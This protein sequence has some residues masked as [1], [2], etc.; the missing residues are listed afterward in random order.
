MTSVISVYLRRSGCSYCFIAAERLLLSLFSCR[1]TAVITV[2]LQ[3]DCCYHR[4]NAEEVVVAEFRSREGAGSIVVKTHRIP[5]NDCSMNERAQITFYK[6]I[7]LCRRYCP[8]TY[9]NSQ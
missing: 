5:E 6:Y 7:E 1:E 9:T 8:D 3:R 4:L 2:L